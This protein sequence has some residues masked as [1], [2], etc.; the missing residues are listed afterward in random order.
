MINKLY[1]L[2]HLLAAFSILLVNAKT[3]ET[4]DAIIV[5]G[6]CEFVLFFCTTQINNLS[7]VWFLLISTLHP[8]PFQMFRNLKRFSLFQKK[9]FI[10]LIKCRQFHLILFYLSTKFRLVIFGKIFIIFQ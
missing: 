6:K 7:L 3:Y 5:E 4:D 9:D 10:D 2:L 8:Q 1:L